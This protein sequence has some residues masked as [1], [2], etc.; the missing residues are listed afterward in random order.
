M[1]D[2]HFDAVL[3]FSVLTCV[4]GDAGQRA[5]VQEATRVL[6]PGGLLY[7]SD[8]WLQTDPRN[9]ARYEAG[10]QR[11]GTYG[12]FD[13]PEGVTVRHH[14]RRWLD[15]LTGGYQR[16]ALDEL[17]VPTMNR[18]TA[19]GFQWFGRKRVTAV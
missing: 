13:L 19:D 6:A 11:Y 5:I 18:N 2:A 8:L 17:Q 12:V 9:I 14:D 7:V 16:L 1:P 15:E 3:L 4:P 10:R